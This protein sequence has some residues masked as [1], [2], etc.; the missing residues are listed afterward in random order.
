MESLPVYVLLP[1]DIKPNI[2]MW[3]QIT[4]ALLSF[5]N[6]DANATV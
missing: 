4:P 2:H 5:L 1:K 3:L 6:F